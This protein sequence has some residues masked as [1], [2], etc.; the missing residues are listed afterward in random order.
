[1]NSIENVYKQIDEQR[2]V[3]VT[4]LNQSR[5]NPIPPNRLSDVCM[6]L[7]ILNELLGGFIAELK[8]NQ[9]NKEKEEYTKAISDGKTA[10]FASSNSR[11]NSIDERQA[12]EM[13]FTRH[14]DLWNLISMAQTH[15]RAEGEERKA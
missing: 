14:K 6:K 8:A 4:L 3:L 15:I 2:A 1:M 12:Y 7:S 13:A 10:T 5:S 11:L 9:L